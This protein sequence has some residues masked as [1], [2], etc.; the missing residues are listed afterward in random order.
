MIRSIA[1]HV[2]VDV[3]KG[4][5]EAL[6][7][8][9]DAVDRLFGCLLA[10][11]AAVFH[12]ALGALGRVRRFNQVLRHVSPPEM[13]HQ[14]AI[15]SGLCRGTRYLLPSAAGVAIVLKYSRASDGAHICSS[16]SCL[17]LRTNFCFIATNGRVYTC[18]S[19]TV[20]VTSRLSLSS[21]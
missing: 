10:L 6:H 19:V 8:G 16:S 20:I 9:T 14:R 12:Q 13:G 18:G 1:D 4:V 2:D 17:L 5:I 15:L 3:A 11:G 7:L 21:R